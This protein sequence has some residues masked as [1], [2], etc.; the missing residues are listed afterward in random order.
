MRINAHHIVNE[1]EGTGLSNDL[2]IADGFAFLTG[3]YTGL[4]I[5]DIDPP[6]SAYTVDT[7]PTW[8]SRGLAVTEGY[9]Y[10]ACDKVGFQV[11]D[12]NSPESANIIKSFEMPVNALS[13]ALSKGYAFVTVYD[14]YTLNHYVQY[15]KLYEKT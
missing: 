6:G 7:V 12:I 14:D 4:E 2:E 15:L 10:V 8:A 13:V 5:I 3:T 1:I 9:A 11:V